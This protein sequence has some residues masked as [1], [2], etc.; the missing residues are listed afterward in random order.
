MDIAALQHEL[1]TLP[2]DQQDRLAAFLTTLRLKRDGR[3]RE[4]SR[5]LDEK[6]PSKWVEWDEAKT[7]LGLD[8]AESGQ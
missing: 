7:R 3:M 6:D 2:G 5:R 1:E 4:I 8:D